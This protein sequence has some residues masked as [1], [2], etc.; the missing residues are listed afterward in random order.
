[1]SNRRCTAAWALLIASL[2]LNGCRTAPPAA[3]GSLAWVEIAGSTPARIREAVTAVFREDG[4]HRVTDSAVATIFEKPGSGMN[5]VAYGGWTSKITI[6]VNVEI[7]SQVTGSHLVHCEAFMV[8]NAGDH[9]IEDSQKIH[10]RHGRYQ[11]LLNRVKVRV[12][13]GA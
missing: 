11:D 7:D 10:F 5:N 6:R 12:D 13:S 9:S 1:M 3:E 8:R 4:Y 2:L